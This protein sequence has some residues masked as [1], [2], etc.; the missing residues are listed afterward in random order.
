MAIYYE[1]NNALTFEVLKKRF[2]NFY[3]I[4]IIKIITFFVYINI[5]K[6]NF[7]K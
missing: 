7:Y 3:G 4:F 1:F 6:L 5:N 2:I